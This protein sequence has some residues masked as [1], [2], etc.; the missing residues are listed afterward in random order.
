MSAGFGWALGL[1]SLG[2]YKAA[3]AEERVAFLESAR[4]LE[5]VRGQV[6]K[7]QQ[8]SLAQESQR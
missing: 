3:T 1:A 8:E 2:Q 6:V 5:R 7:A 4:L